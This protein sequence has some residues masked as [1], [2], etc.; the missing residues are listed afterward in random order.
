MRRYFRAGRGE[1]ALA[2]ALLALTGLMIVYPPSVMWDL[3]A[4][5]L[6]VG[7]YIGRRS[8]LRQQ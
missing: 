6:A 2:G 8:P 4:E 1:W 5:A 7:F 3:A